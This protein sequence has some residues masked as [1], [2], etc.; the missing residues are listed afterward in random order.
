MSNP[1]AIPANPVPLPVYNPELPLYF[2]HVFKCAGT[3]VRLMVEDLVPAERNFPRGNPSLGTA[4]PSSGRMRVW[5]EPLE[6]Y[7]FL[8]GHCG[9]VI[10]RKY[11]KPLNIFMWL[12]EPRS[13]LIS[14]F[15]F[16]VS[17]NQLPEMDARLKAGERR[18]TLFMEYLRAVQAGPTKLQKEILGMQRDYPLELWQQ[19]NPGK[20]VQ[21]GVLEALHACFF[22]GL[23]EEHDASL[24]ALCAQIGALPPR[25]VIRRNAYAVKQDPLQFTP[26]EEAEISQA[27]E[28]DYQLY[29]Y[30]QELYRRKLE[31]LRAEGARNPLYAAIGDRGKLRQLILEHAHGAGL[32]TLRGSWE[33]TQPVFGENLDEHQA[34]TKNGLFRHCRWTSPRE[35][36]LLYFNLP[37][38]RAYNLDVRISPATR[39]TAVQQVRVFLAGREISLFRT[40]D[41]IG[42]KTLR[43]ALG[44]QFLRSLPEIVEL[45]ILTPEMTDESKVLATSTRK[46]GIALEGITLSPLLAAEA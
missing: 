31:Y 3:S 10:P 27:L 46:V 1:F 5:N 37:R 4:Y 34:Y 35:E 13:R 23:M 21:E 44:R 20:T 38:D 9:M 30:A 2:L 17:M 18:E 39:E 25:D 29:A 28:E 12:R 16:S 14:D 32:L 6:G 36:T 33:C 43:A 11:G 24:D 19:D 7:D 15:L 26:E 40:T 8:V 41:D 45:R 22:I 42:V